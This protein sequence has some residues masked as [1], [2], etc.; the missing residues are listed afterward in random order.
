[1]TERPRPPCREPGGRHTPSPGR[2]PWVKRRGN[3]ARPVKGGLQ[4]K[5]S[6]GR[7]FSRFYRGGPEFAATSHR[8]FPGKDGYRMSHTFSLLLYHIVFGTQHRAAF[9]D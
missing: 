6:D 1:M 3:S 2:Q 5:L 8:G 9:I 4:K 7:R